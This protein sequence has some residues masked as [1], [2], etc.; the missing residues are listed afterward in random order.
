VRTHS[1]SGFTLI[2]SLIVV[3]VSLVLAGVAAPIF[4]NAID[5]YRLSA[6]VS[7][8]T[9]A[10]QSARFQAIMKGYPYQLIFTSSNVS[11]QLYNEVPPATT[12][13]TVGPA[14]PLPSAGPITMNG[15]TTFTYTFS[16]NGIVTWSPSQP[17]MQIANAVKSCTITVSGVGNVSTSCT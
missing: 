3:A 6:T 16:P 2:E 17:N 15:A 12:F 10:I 1:N 11:Y 8:A 7:A 4:T 14:N 13:S 5:N 9:G